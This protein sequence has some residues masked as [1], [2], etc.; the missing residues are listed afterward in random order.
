M[1]IQRAIFNVS[2][3]MPRN[4]VFLTVLMMLSAVVIID[5]AA[6]LFMHTKMISYGVRVMCGFMIVILTWLNWPSC[7]AVEEHPHMW[8]IQ[9]SIGP[10]VRQLRKI[11]PHQTWKVRLTKATED[12]FRP[13]R[14]YKQ[15]G[16][17]IELVEGN[18][19][20]ICILPK[21]DPD[22]RLVYLDQERFADHYCCMVVNPESFRDKPVFYQMHIIKRAGIKIGDDRAIDEV[23]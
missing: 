23:D 6:A 13:I 14:Y 16:Y 1:W 20:D 8:A 15:F 9:S 21:M 19:Y 17:N 12:C 11:D 7:D 3:G 4:G 2:L 10:L 5:K 18:E 22:S